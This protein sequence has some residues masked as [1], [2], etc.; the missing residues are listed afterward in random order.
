MQV[1]TR[2]DS[3]VH[4][5]TTQYISEVNMDAIVGMMSGRRASSS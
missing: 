2:T 5:R 4:K 3:P 1:V